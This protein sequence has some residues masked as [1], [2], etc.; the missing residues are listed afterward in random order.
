[1]RELFDTLNHAVAG[2]PLI[3]LAAAL[4]WG[5]LSMVLSPCHLA[6]I[7]LVVGFIHGQGPASAR[8]ALGLSASFAAG[9]LV[10]IAV[11][12][13]ATAAAGRVLGDVGRYTNYAVA[14][15]FF[16]VGLHLLDVIPL[17]LAGRANVGLKSRGVAAA[18]ILGAVFGLALGPCTFAYMAPVLAVTFKVAASSLTFGVLLLAM[19]GIGH[20]SVIVAAGSSTRLVQRYLD[21]DGGKASG[22]V[23]RACGVLV[24]LAGINLIYTA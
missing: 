15:V 24:L 14:G 8:R 13:L 19:Y 1:M 4:V 22:F 23:K 12:G 10:S 5:M 11:I 17:P 20:C 16:L 21:W 18:L 2:T 7:P 9:V 3:A 6:S